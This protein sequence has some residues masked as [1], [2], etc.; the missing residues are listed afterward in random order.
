MA[1]S[2]TTPHSAPAWLLRGVLV[3]GLLLAAINVASYFTCSTGWG[4]LLGTR[5]EHREGIG[6]PWEIWTS[7]NAYGGYYVDY[8]RLFQNG[9]VA[10]GLGTV[11]GLWAISQRRW[12]DAMW[13]DFERQSR[14]EGRRRFQFS[15]R[16]L[17]FAT[18]L[19]ALVAALWKH[20]IAGQP[21]SLGAIYTAGPWL[22]IG[23]ALLPR[24]LSWQQRVAVLVPMT[25]MLMTGAVF[26]GRTLPLRRDVDQVLLGI[27]VCWTPQTAL[28]ACLLMTGL[29]WRWRNGRAA[30]HVGP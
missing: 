21:W 20:W 8:R 5:P 27:F 28:A 2:A 1:R 18:C 13:D 9:M 11:L 7:G 19:T 17:F 4:N 3:G 12:L 25:L 23:I 24:G 30:N 14:A 6:F 16:E 22:L 26:I 15:L 29:V 10:L